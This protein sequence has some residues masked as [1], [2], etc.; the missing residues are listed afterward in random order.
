MQEA[1]GTHAAASGKLASTALRV[2]LAGLASLHPGSLHTRK[3]PRTRGGLSVLSSPLQRPPAALSPTVNVSPFL[4]R[5][6]FF[7]YLLSFDRSLKSQFL[8]P[9]MPG[10]L[11]HLMKSSH[12]PIKSLLQSQNGR[13]WRSLCCPSPQVVSSRDPRPCIPWR[14][15]KCRL[16]HSASPTMAP[17]ALLDPSTK[18][19]TILLSLWV[20]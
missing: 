15:F 9:Q 16:D 8:S 13:S 7:L 4:S 6:C 18:Q 12:F 17:K 20:A 19:T 3:P 2:P 5:G 14:P 10:L 11:S 1:D